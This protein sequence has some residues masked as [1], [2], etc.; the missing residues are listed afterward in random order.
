MTDED[1]IS[2][3]AVWKVARQTRLR[4]LEQRFLERNLR[5]FIFDDVGFNGQKQKMDFRR[6]NGVS[7]CSTMENRRMHGGGARVR[8]PSNLIILPKILIYITRRIEGK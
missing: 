7:R 6:W 4:V 3:T 2:E 1:R 8:S 5:G